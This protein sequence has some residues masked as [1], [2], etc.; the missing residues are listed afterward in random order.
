M[1]V[2]GYGQHPSFADPQVM[3]VEVRPN[4]LV[5]SRLSGVQAACMPVA[6]GTINWMQVQDFPD[7]DFELQE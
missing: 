4:E 1:I 5:F 2:L 7:G 3:Q 6:E